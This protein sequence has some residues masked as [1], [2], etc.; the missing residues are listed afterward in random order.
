[1]KK[2]RQITFLLASF[3]AFGYGLAD[4]AGVRQDVADSVQDNLGESRKYGFRFTNPESYEKFL[5]FQRTLAG[6]LIDDEDDA[7]LGYLEANGEESLVGCRFMGGFRSIVRPLLSRGVGLLQPVYGLDAEGR[8]QADWAQT[9]RVH[10]LLSKELNL[11][12]L[13]LDVSRQYDALVRP[14]LE[15]QARELAEARDY[16][17]MG[18]GG[19]ASPAYFQ[20]VLARLPEHAYLIEPS[21]P[22]LNSIVES[23]GDPPGILQLKTTRLTGWAMKLDSFGLDITPLEK[24]RAMTKP[25]LS[26]DQGCYYHA[27]PSFRALW[28]QTDQRMSWFGGGRPSAE[29]EFRLA[30]EKFEQAQVSSQARFVSDLLPVM[31]RAFEQFRLSGAIRSEKLR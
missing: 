26:A 8:P 25:G 19:F 20:Q 28:K 21:K 30:R 2:L 7:Y 15:G 11:N 1:M 5:A 18:Y 24:Y 12:L 31:K 9:E 27:I 22:V 3:L 4:M 10:A 29:A 14:Y 6:R 23:A 16:I 13:P 17:R